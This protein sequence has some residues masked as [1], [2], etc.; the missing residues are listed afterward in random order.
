MKIITAEELLAFAKKQD[1]ARIVNMMQNDSAS[2]CGCLMVQYGKEE[3]KI[4]K[5]FTCGYSGF[6]GNQKI[7]ER[8]I[9]EILGCSYSDSFNYGEIVKRI[10]KFIAAKKRKNRLHS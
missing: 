8:P 10:K 9:S 7:L 5:R 3:L 1:T 2:E 4:K 6:T